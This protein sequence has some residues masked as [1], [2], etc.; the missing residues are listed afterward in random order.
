MTS[1]RIAAAV[2]LTAAASVWGQEGPASAGAITLA[3]RAPKDALIVVAW[4]GADQTKPVFDQSRL[5]QLWNDEAL[6]KGLCEPLGAA[7]ALIKENAADEGKEAEALLF[8]QIASQIWRN[9]GI[10]CLF[11][12]EPTDDYPASLGVA[13]EW[14]APPNG[15]ELAKEIASTISDAL[16]KDAKKIKFG[17]TVYTRISMD[18]PIYLAMRK[19]HWIV[20]FGKKT[21]DA[22]AKKRSGARSFAQNACHK[23]AVE[24]LGDIKPFFYTC[25]HTE[26]LNAHLRKALAGEAGRSSASDKPA[27]SQ[28]G[29]PNKGSPS[30]PGGSESSWG[31]QAT[32]ASSG[33]TL[34]FV[35]FFSDI[36]MLGSAEC[37]NAVYFDGAELHEVSYARASEEHPLPFDFVATKPVDLKHLDAAPI[38]TA[39]FSLLTWEPAAMYA[40][41]LKTIAEWGREYD[42]AFAKTGSSTL[43]EDLG[44]YI[45]DELGLDVEKDLLAHLGD[46]ILFMGFRERAD[47][48]YVVALDLQDTAAVQGF[49]DKVIALLPKGIEVKPIEYENAKAY[50]L[51]FQDLGLGGPTTPASLCFAVTEG[52]LLLGVQMAAIRRYLTHAKKDPSERR[53]LLSTGVLESFLETHKDQKLSWIQYEDE[54]KIFTPMYK[55]LAQLVLVTN[56]VLRAM[57]LPI[58]LGELPS[59][60][61]FTNPMME[62]YG[63]TVVDG[64]V[65]IRHDLS[66][67][68]ISSLWLNPS[69]LA[70][71]IGVT[72]PAISRARATA[73]RSLCAANLN[74]IG[75]AIYLH[76]NEHDGQF[77][78][79]LDVLLKAEAIESKMLVCPA[80]GRKEG[81]PKPCYAYIAGQ[82]MKSDP[83]NVLVYD[84]EAFHGSE[85]AN[86][87]FQDGHVEFVTPYARVAELVEETK[88][89][90]AK[91][92]S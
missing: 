2:L 66:G 69:R 89:R 53:T 78:E 22:M 19:G 17:K 38:N 28:P 4:S 14:Q 72:L 49:V 39:F 87:L 82:T 23:R 75:Q 1:L 31:F 5:G 88:Q 43:P 3:E 30:G 83:K 84:V 86:V 54:A 8:E 16:G 68:P 42:Q 76:A 52:R 9:P 48:V 73:R 15:A 61:S 55:M 67:I 65:R 90:L 6:Q 91:Q 77:P 11:P 50:T 40:Q 81:D 41:A 36:S 45:A 24:A 64:P 33:V 71:I 44:K 12:I 21:A 70:P 74:G 32:L 60:R 85:G 10:A 13:F 58:S 56:S 20:A 63:W 57:Q 35:T 27:S 18:P 25:V 47:V 92:G 80:S 46:H 62:A 51:S 7:W 26:Q 79:N 37:A 59:V 29:S 34:A